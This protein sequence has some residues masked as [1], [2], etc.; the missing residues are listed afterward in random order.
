MKKLLLSVSALAIALSASAQDDVICATGWDDNFT[1]SDVPGTAPLNIIYWGNSSDSP[2]FDASIGQYN[3]RTR[4][5]GKLEISVTQPKNGWTPMGFD[6]GETTNYVDISS[7]QTISVSVTNN[8]PTGVECYWDFISGRTTVDSP[9]GAKMVSGDVLGSPFGGIIA[10]GATENWTF[11]LNGAKKRTWVAGQADCDALGGTLL[12]SSCMTDAGFDPT[13]LSTGEFSVNGQG[14]S[15]D[16]AWAQPAITDHSISI[17]YIRGGD[18]AACAGSSSA[19]DLAAIG[20]SVFPN[21]AT[22]VVNVNVGSATGASVQLVD[23]TGKVVAAATGVSGT[24]ALS[25]SDVPA[26]LYVVN[27]ASAAGNSTSKVLVK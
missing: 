5:G 27:V 4:T 21:P 23:V 12:G 7:N 2:E 11:D 14:A 25:I 10:A 18:Y 22:D 20:G 3:N 9:G 13:E 17:D 8:G 1:S 16:G 26:G 19:T 24:V 6:L 15:V